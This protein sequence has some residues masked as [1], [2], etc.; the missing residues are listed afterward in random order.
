MKKN[1]LF[2]CCSEKV[3]WSVQH[4]GTRHLIG[5]TKRG[6]D[7][8]DIVH[9]QADLKWWLTPKD[10]HWSPKSYHWST[11][12]EHFPPKILKI[13]WFK[14]IVAN[15]CNRAFCCKS[16]RECLLVVWKDPS[17]LLQTNSSCVA[18]YLRLCV[19]QQQG[20]NK[21]MAEADVARC[22]DVQTVDWAD[23][24]SR[25]QSSLE[26]ADIGLMTGRG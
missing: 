6:W 11:I 19:Q 10:D 20:V 4:N 25:R 1:T 5:N 8:F 16:T 14:C 26:D 7:P 15:C 22:T 2:I 17:L 3:K 18:D 13:C 12:F 21:A 9:V 23:S 24:Q